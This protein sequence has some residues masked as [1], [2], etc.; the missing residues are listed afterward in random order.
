MYFEKRFMLSSN[1]DNQEVVIHAGRRCRKILFRNRYTELESN[2]F[3]KGKMYIL[4]ILNP[5]TIPKI[6]FVSGYIFPGLVFEVCFHNL[7]PNTKFFIW[8]SLIFGGA[9]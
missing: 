5:N 4:E 6:C 8:T 9:I 1:E 2:F 3:L 7:A